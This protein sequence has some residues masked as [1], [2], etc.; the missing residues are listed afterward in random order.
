[1]YELWCPASAVALYL[2]LELPLRTA[3]VRWLD[4]GEADLWRY[5]N[6]YWVKNTGK[7][8]PATKLDLSR[9]ILNLF[10]IIVTNMCPIWYNCLKV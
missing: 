3:Q 2:K 10:C 1:M 9:F 4:S 7:L 8:A 5:Q 6:G